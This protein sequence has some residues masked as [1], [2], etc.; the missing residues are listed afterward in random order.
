MEASGRIVAVRRPFGADFWQREEK[1]PVLRCLPFDQ[2]RLPVPHEQCELP[3]GE[4]D[5]DHFR[6]SETAG[7]RRSSAVYL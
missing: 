1:K 7:N 2:E 4:G 3:A 5:A 6:W